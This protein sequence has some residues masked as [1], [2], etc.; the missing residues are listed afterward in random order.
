[1]ISHAT[2]GEHPVLKAQGPSFRTSP[3]GPEDGLV[4]DFAEQ[5]TVEGSSWT[6][7][8]FREPR[9]GTT[10]PDL[11]LVYWR[12]WIA[13]KWPEERRSL[14]RRDFRVLQC[15][16]GL[17]QAGA[18]TLSEFFGRDLDESLK[19]LAL[20][21]LVFQASHTW[22][23]RSV[24]D[25]F[26]V[27]RL[28]AVEAKIKNWQEGLKQAARNRSFASESYLLLDAYPSSSNIV[29]TA[30]SLN[31]GLLKSEGGLSSPYL[32]APERG[33]PSSYA[34]W[35]FNDWAWRSRI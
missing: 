31:V 28:I 11:V 4:A 1:M 33:L 26:A 17:G 30:E 32:P 18:G 34:S 29:S 12:P 6:L 15:L 35:L 14:H 3:G 13:E 23:P 20:A 21:D 22:R 9:L 7:T 2:V 25:S 10:F 24:K 19:R 5:L 8:R 27:S 16:R